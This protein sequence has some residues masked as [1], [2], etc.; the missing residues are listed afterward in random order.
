V[1]RDKAK[2]VI[3]FSFLYITATV[4]TSKQYICMIFWYLDRDFMINSIS[5][6]FAERRGYNSK[7]VLPTYSIIHDYANIR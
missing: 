2:A 3:R 5:G 4:R 7:G 6:F 1:D